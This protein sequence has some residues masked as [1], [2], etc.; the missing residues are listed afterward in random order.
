MEPHFYQD[1]FLKFQHLLKV[2]ILKNNQVQYYADKMGV[3]T[4]KINRITQA[5]IGKSAKDYINELL[6]LEIKRFLINTNL[7]VKEIAYKTGFEIPT[8]FVKFFRK[9]TGVTPRTFRG[10]F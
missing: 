7:S 2:D 10:Q 9:N 3:S 6:V 5:I 4:K 8:N 1:D